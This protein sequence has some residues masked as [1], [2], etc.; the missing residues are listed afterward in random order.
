MANIIRVPAGVTR[1]SLSLD[2]T[3]GS[4]ALYAR[5]N[6]CQDGMETGCALVQAGTTGTLALE[7]TP[8]S[9]VAVMVDAHGGTP[10]QYT[11]RWAPV[12]P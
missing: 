5:V 10:E 1:I 6:G 8:Q 2:V 9:A 12:T 7:V 4:A 3:G 11:L